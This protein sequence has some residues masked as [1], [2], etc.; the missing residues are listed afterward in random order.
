MVDQPCCACLFPHTLTGMAEPRRQMRCIGRA[1]QAGLGRAG[2]WLRSAASAASSASTAASA[3]GSAGE[4]SA[5]AAPGSSRPTGTCRLLA[6]AAVSNAASR[7]ARRACSCACSAAEACAPGTA[8]RLQN[9]TGCRH[10]ESC[11]WGALPVSDTEV[12]GVCTDCQRLNADVHQ[13]LTRQRCLTQCHFIADSYGEGG[14][15]QAAAAASACAP[16]LARLPPL[17]HRRASEV[18]CSSTRTHANSS[19]VCNNRGGA[20][21]HLQHQTRFTVC[22]LAHAQALLLLLLQLLA[23]A[24]AAPQQPSAPEHAY[25]HTAA[26]GARLSRRHVGGRC[27]GRTHA[28]PAS[29]G[30]TGGGGTRIGARR[31][32][33]RQ[34][35]AGRCSGGPAPAPALE[36]R[37][38]AGW[39]ARRP[40]AAPAAPARA[41][42]PQPRSAAGPRAA[43]CCDKRAAAAH[44]PGRPGRQAGAC[45][46]R[47]A[48]PARAAPHPG[49]GTGR[50]WGG[51][52]RAGRPP[53][54]WACSWALYA[55]R[56]P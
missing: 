11:G 27:R 18:S 9:R 6:S 21:R 31:R 34:G 12:G 43:A 53:R 14:Q 35:T 45:R 15:V 4:G 55:P 20:A 48:L 5:G 26:T 7:R 13:C 2:T 47:R 56:V 38:G 1:R 23:R 46:R 19:D 25:R 41:G 51:G 50:P 36:R 32:A 29:L 16:A 40:G 37:P 30:S 10:L 3:A 49:L 22:L 39:R 54:A 33:H 8:T 17:L 42:E 28:A 44:A 24:R 52:R